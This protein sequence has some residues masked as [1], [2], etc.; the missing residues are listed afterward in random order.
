MS[1]NCELSLVGLV[2]VGSGEGCML[3]S[4]PEMS[5][6]QA[7]VA[8]SRKLPNGDILQQTA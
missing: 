1:L 6:L 7:V 8:V 2:L 4:I 3:G 5:L